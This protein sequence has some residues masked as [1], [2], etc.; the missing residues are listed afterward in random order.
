MTKIL[1]LYKQGD[2]WYFDDKERGIIKE[3]FV[4]GSS[5]IISFTVGKE[6]KKAKLTFSNNDIFP[7]SLI[8]TE[9][10]GDWT[11]YY[12]AELNMYGW[13]CPVLYRYFASPPEAIWFSLQ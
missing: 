1:E 12:S 2:T 13:L 6:V 7:H 5:Q 9:I 10:K 8:R 3:P 11:E 4:Q